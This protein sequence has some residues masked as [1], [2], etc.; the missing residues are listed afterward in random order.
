MSPACRNQTAW[1]RDVDFKPWVWYD[2]DRQMCQASSW[3]VVPPPHQTRESG[4]S[5]TFL[6]VLPTSYNV[7][8]QRCVAHMP[9][10]VMDSCIF[11]AVI[12]CGNGTR[13]ASTQ[14][15]LG[16]AERNKSHILGTSMGWT[17]LMRAS[18]RRRIFQP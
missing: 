11:S 5:G 2:G 10:G 12:W 9:E 15:F 8:S 17:W 13:P 7:M 14:D 6:K 18:L 3:L 1:C 16:Q 4:A